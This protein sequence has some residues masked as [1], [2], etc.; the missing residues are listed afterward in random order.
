[1]ARIASRGRSRNRL[2]P[3]R[4]ATL[5][6][7]AA[8]NVVAPVHIGKPGRRTGAVLPLLSADGRISVLTVQDEKS[9]SGS[10]LAQTLAASLALREYSAG[11]VDI[12]LDSRTIAEALQCAALAEGAQLLV[13][14]GFG[15]SR[16]HDFILGGA[17]MGVFS[18]LQ[19]AVLLSH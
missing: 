5:V 14:G 15:H 4:A 19:L 10:S 2:T 17:T 6:K 16:L 11:T 12:N 7:A 18:D 9:H 8:P 1:M 3:S 13:M